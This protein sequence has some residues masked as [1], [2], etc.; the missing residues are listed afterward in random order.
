MLPD[1]IP[2]LDEEDLAPRGVAGHQHED[3]LLFGHAG[4]VIEVAVLAVLVAHVERVVPHRRAEEDQHRVGPETLHHACTSGLQV[5]AV[6]AGARG[7][8]RDQHHEREH[9]EPRGSGPHVGS[10]HYFSSQ[11]SAL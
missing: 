5:V 11:L 3:R 10:S 9:G 2:I 8:R 7:R 1:R 6:L 4:E